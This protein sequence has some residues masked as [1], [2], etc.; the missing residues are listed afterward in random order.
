MFSS[1]TQRNAKLLIASCTLFISVLQARAQVELIAG[2]QCGGVVERVYWQYFNPDVALRS[3][4][5]VDRVSGCS[6]IM[7]GPNIMMTAG[8]CGPST[9]KARFRMYKSI[10]G[11]CG[12]MSEGDQS[13]QDFPMEWVLNVFPHTDLQLVYCHAVNGVNPGDKYG[14]VDLDII[15]TPQG[16][17]DYTASRNLLAPATPLYSIWFNPINNIN[18]W[19][20]LYSEGT[21]SDLNIEDYSNPN[22]DDGTP[23]WHCATSR[24]VGGS[25]NGMIC[26]GC[27]TV[28]CPGGTCVET[29]DQY[30]AVRSS[31]YVVPGGSGSAVLSPSSHRILLGPTTGGNGTT[32]QQLS[33]VD[34]LYWGLTWQ[35]P[36]CAD[37]CGTTLNS[38]VLTS[39]GLNPP[40]Y[41][42][43][44][45]RNLDGL[46]DVQHDLEMIAGEGRRD[47]YWLGFESMRR[48]A[49]WTKNL[50][51]VTFD[52][53][54]PVSGFANL[55]TVGEVGTN[56]V[57]VLSH[58][59]L[60]LGTSPG[61]RTYSIK[62]TAYCSQ[63]S[64]S[65]PLRICLEGPNTVCET[66]DPPLNSSMTYVVHIPATYSAQGTKLQFY[67]KPGTQLKLDS[68]SVVEDGAVMDF[69]MHDKRIA[70]RNRNSIGRGLI[71]PNGRNSENVPDWAGV[72][73]R[74]PTRPLNDDWPLRNLNIPFG[75]G[76]EYRICF[77][78]KK[79]D[80]I[81]LTSGSSGVVR[82]EN[83]FGEISGSRL[84]F[85]PSTSWQTG[86][87]SWFLVT[88]NSSSLDFGVIAAN[89]SAS[90]AY[91]VDNVV[92]ERRPTTF[93]VDWRN[94]GFEDGTQVFPYN[95]VTEGVSAIG[96]GGTLMIANGTSA[97]YP[98]TMTIDKAVTLKAYNGVV[99]I[100]Q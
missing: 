5:A 26:S 1:A 32:R 83:Q 46:F 91:L 37:G 52:A 54:H 25:N 76:Y 35:T 15:M 7:I 51:S 3:Y 42:G 31:V 19:H 40:D 70:W 38:P 97:N 69:D 88:S 24:C 68:L 18:G 75:R 89:G 87:T 28:E 66:F 36:C 8:H 41:Y 90:G 57:L 20:S 84:V 21:L 61:T 82:V 14:Y 23:D 59:R 95:T 80:R 63:K 79:A 2:E 47:W 33:I 16:V 30:L 55:S 64:Q 12:G 34:Y 100:G 50:S 74:T 86:C 53:S 72:V 43:W 77:E 58:D 99:S 92:L 62:F 11:L 6:G 17:L 73:Q 22:I 56:Y 94:P 85:A 49:L 13:I 98:Q 93:Y 65:D 45:D 27:C 81:P 39:K 96:S 71:W 9:D 78:Y 29:A 44:V 60:N 4:A 10:A 67:L 48:N